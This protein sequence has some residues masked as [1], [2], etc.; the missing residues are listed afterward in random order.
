MQQDYYFALSNVIMASA[1][2]NPELRRKIYEL[3]RSKLR[4]QL[5]WEGSELS[6]ADKAQQLLALETAIKQ[7]EADLARDVSPQPHSGALAAITDSKI[8][9]IPPSPRPP[10]LSEPRYQSGSVRAARQKSSAMWSVWPLV[11]AA[12]LGVA[13]YVAVERG[14]Y[15]NPQA[16]AQA[17]HTVPHDSTSGHPLPLP[18]PT[19]YGIYALSNGELME[20]EPL[21]VKIPDRG[22]A[23]SGTLSTA[24]TT[25]LSNGRAQFI[26]FR[27][28]L[29]NNVPEKVMVRI[30]AQ[31]VRASAH[32]GENT[33]RDDGDGWA[34]RSVSYEMKVAPIDGNPAMIVIRPADTGFSFPAGRYALMLKGTAYDFSVNGPITDQAQCVE[35]A[36]EQ[37]SPVYIQCRQ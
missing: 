7:I 3:A 34:I 31:I 11:A 15:E 32:K 33:T 18:M 20:L 4:R 5:D 8:E 19:G 36:E 35:L 12:I 24:S 29:V 30:V 1:R 26:A 9:I 25:K 16:G 22:G 2:D 21:P 37:N 23:I 13:A 28:D 6:H 14:V 27:R 10:P 17:D